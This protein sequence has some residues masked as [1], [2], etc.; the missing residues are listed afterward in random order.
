MW[1]SYS[2]IP[3]AISYLLKR[4]YTVNPKPQLQC[5][6]YFEQV[7]TIAILLPSWVA[8]TDVAAK[9]FHLMAAVT[10]FAT[11][12]GLYLGSIGIMEK[13]IETIRIMGYIGF[14]I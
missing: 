8:T 11:I 6:R 3:K 2:N 14:R 1:G 7:V 4:D 5:L 13:Q 10:A 12:K 9:E